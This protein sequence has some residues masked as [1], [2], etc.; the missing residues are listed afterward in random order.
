MR[1]DLERFGFGSSC[2]SFLA[3][4]FGLGLLSVA[5]VCG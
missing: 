1:V 3:L 5:L 4:C 2:G